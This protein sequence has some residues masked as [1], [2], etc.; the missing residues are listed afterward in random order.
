MLEYN[1][2]DVQDEKTFDP[3]ASGIYEGE[4]I[5][6]DSMQSKAGNDMVRLNVLCTNDDGNTTR[7]YD[8]IVVPSTLYK[9]KS[10][11]R[12]LNWD[13][14][15]TLDEQELVGQRF[16]VKLGIDKGSKEYPEPKNRIDRYV[17]GLTN[18]TPNVE[19]PI[20]PQDDDVPF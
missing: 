4:I 8:Y 20:A 5:E 1:P 15:G 16:K 12:C 10:I 14:S 19:K 9:L 2:E 6:A 13:F 3:W 18:S 11:C 17:E 7:I